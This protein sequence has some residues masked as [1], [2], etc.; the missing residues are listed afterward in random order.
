MSGCGLRRSF[1]FAFSAAARRWLAQESLVDIVDMVDAMDG[2]C[3]RARH[4]FTLRG[5]LR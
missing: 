5:A 4:F 1:T 3:A 2:T